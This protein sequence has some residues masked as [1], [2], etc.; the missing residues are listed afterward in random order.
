M[1]HTPYH[2][3]SDYIQMLNKTPPKKIVLDKRQDHITND[4]AR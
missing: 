2:V 4:E 1:I 3:D